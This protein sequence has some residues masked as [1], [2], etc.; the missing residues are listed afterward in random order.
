MSKFL[1]KDCEPMEVTVPDKKRRK[2]DKSSNSDFVEAMKAV[3][4]GIKPPPLPPARKPSDGVESLPD[5]IRKVVVGLGHLINMH[6]FAA[7]QRAIA[8]FRDGATKLAVQISDDMVESSI[9]Q[10]FG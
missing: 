9:D 8:K 7:D 2:T 5:S 1:P 10:F 4:S 6:G 3:M